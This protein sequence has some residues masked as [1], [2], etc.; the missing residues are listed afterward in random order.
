[1]QPHFCRITRSQTRHQIT[2]INHLSL[3]LCLSTYVFVCLSLSLSASLFYFILPLSLSLSFFS[4][5]FSVSLSFLSINL[6]IYLF[7]WHKQTLLFLISS[8]GK[9]LPNSAKET[10]CVLQIPRHWQGVGIQRRNFHLQRRGKRA[11]SEEEVSTD[12][13]FHQQFTSRFYTRRSQ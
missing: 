4:L 8:F 2:P 12:S 10:F 6:S 5:S 11:T 13:P 7:I 1:M 9:I 3:S